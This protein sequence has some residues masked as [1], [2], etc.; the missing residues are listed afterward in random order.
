MMRTLLSAALVASAFALPATAPSASA[1]AHDP[2]AQLHRPL[3]LKPLAPRAR[4]PVT[5]RRPL[6]GGRLS[7]IGTGPA[8]PTGFSF[9]TDSRHPSW[10]ASKTI[11][12]WPAKLLTRRVRVLVRASR[13]DRPGQI[14]FQLGPQWDT[15]P[16]TREL[17]LDTTQPVGS[18]S[19]SRWGTT[20]TLLFVRAPGCYGL[21]LDTAAGTSTIVFRATRTRR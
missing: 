12:T 14:R 16:L 15:A 18:F 10:L 8:Y 20:V 9:S 2:W 1:V 6:D 19:N 17:H 13:L 5:P 3:R 7:G 4:C 21:Q 11:W